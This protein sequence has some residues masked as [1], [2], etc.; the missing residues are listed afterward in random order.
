MT[1]RYTTQHQP[2]KHLSFD[3]RLVFEQACN[4]N[5]RTPKQDRL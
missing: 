1:R 2:K 5:L 3:Q 4:D